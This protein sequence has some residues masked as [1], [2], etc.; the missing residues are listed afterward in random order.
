MPGFPPNLTTR[1]PVSNHVRRSLL[2][3]TLALTLILAAA[4]ALIRQ[5]TLTS[6]AY[7]S[8]PRTNPRFLRKHVDFLTIDVRPRGADQP[9][10]LD[11][12]ADYIAAEFEKSGAAVTTQPFNKK[13]KNVIARFGPS[14]GRALLVGAHYDAF[15]STAALPGADDNASGTAGLLELARLLGTVKPKRP[16]VLIAW[17]AEEPPFYG[18]RL[19][20]SAV[21]ADSVD[22]NDVEAVICLEMIGYFRGTQS[23]PNA[24]FDLLYPDRTDFIAVGGGWDDRALVR[25][26]KRGIRGAGGVDV[27]SFVGPRAALHG[28]D[29][30]NYWAA[31]MRAVLVTDTA[32]LR[33]P[34]Y[35][36]VRDTADTLDYEKMA[37][38]VDGIFNAIR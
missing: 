28:S 34:N 35:H 23:W 9:E 2:R 25:Q 17:S 38:V 31:G 37:G 27:L 12:A 29:H 19:M 24:I 10:N 15:T 32:F 6:I 18:S 36:T 33:N 22:A 13:Y 8:L 21:H 3:I 1:P 7:G 14:T 16:I 20:G 11:K 26:V 30:E 5:P 4:V